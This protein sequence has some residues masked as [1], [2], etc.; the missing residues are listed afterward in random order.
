MTECRSKIYRPAWRSFYWYWLFCW[1]VFPVFIMLWKKY[2]Y[3]L[4]LKPD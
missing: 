1:L 3:A 2:S 4:I